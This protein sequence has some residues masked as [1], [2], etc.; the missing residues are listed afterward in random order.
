MAEPRKRVIELGRPGD[1]VKLLQ[2]I[3]H[4]QQGIA[5]VRDRLGHRLHDRPALLGACHCARCSATVEP[6]HKLL[7]F[8]RPA[9]W[10]PGL[11]VCGADLPRHKIKSSHGDGELAGDA[12]RR[13]GSPFEPVANANSQLSALVHEVNGSLRSRGPGMRWRS[14][15]QDAYV[16]IT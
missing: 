1:M 12:P 2:R 8:D 7:I 9:A 16:A 14:G 11:G 5:P 10:L 13:R 6:T 15:W 3:D 4:D